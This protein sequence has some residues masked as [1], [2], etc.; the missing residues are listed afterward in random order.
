MTS[1]QGLVG[2]AN[3]ANMRPNSTGI[4]CTCHGATAYHGGDGQDYHARAPKGWAGP[5]PVPTGDS[6]YGVPIR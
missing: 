4:R 6:T 5:A 1:Q 2:R 3:M